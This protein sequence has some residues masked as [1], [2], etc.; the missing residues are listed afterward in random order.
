M[1][2]RLLG[3]LTLLLMA[4]VG[5]S[6]QVRAQTVSPASDGSTLKQIILF[7]RHGVHSAAV[8]DS[9]LSK[10][11]SRPYPNFG[12]PAGYLTEHGFQAEQL[13]GDYFRSYL[14]KE[15]LLSGDVNN[16]L[17]HSYFR[18]NSIQRSNLSAAALG[19]GMLPGAAV[20]VHSYALGTPDAIFDPIAAKLV[21]FDAARARGARH[22]QF[23][24]GAARGVR[25]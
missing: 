23:G 8:P 1:T 11:A 13:L 19:A 5:L 4:G 21:T 15:G 20:P 18:A 2:K 22:L 17:A 7:G 16:E 9:V 6:S 10:F 12:V 24:R 25:S 14:L 3:R